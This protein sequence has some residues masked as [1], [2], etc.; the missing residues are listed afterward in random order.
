MRSA[1]TTMLVGVL[2]LTTGTSSRAQAQVVTW[3]DAFDV[4]QNWI[5]LIIEKEG[6]WGGAERA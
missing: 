6:S 3:G 2:F 4:A 1:I 5:A